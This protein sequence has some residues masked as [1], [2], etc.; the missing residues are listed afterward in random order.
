MSLGKIKGKPPKLSLAKHRAI[1]V[2]GKSPRLRH[3][4]KREA[5]AN[6][7]KARPSTC[8]AKTIRELMS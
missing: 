2:P 4:M 5:E 3:A 1:G 7:R 6:E 8:T